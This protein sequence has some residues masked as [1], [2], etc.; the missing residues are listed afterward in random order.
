MKK[1][2]LLFVTTLVA[3]FVF[4]A[5]LFAQETNDAS[6]V[7]RSST[8]IEV[9]GPGLIT[10]F[11]YDLRIRN[12]NDGLG[13][14]LGVGGFMIDGDGL[15]AVPA[16]LNYLSG[17]RGKYFEVGA[18][19]TYCSSSG[20]IF[21]TDT[22]TDSNVIGTLTFGYRY[23][24]NKGGVNFRVGLSPIFGNNDDGGY[25]IPYLPYLSLGYTFPNRNR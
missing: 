9:G 21:M 20:T 6:R 22:E 2:I 1:T 14:R 23:Q 16:Q 11:N 7:A 24:P 5:N 13:V 3:Y 10:S 12:V 8:Y 15:F 25:F 19:I 4:S 18:G 17:K